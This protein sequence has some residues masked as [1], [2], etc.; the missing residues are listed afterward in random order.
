MTKLPRLLIAAIG[1]LLSLIACA[2]AQPVPAWLDNDPGAIWRRAPGLY[3]DGGHWYAILHTRPDIRR[4]RLVADFTDGSA[5]AFDLTPTP[6]GKFWWLKGRQTDFTRPPSAGDC[7]RFELTRHDG[8]TER[9]QDPAAR[10]VESSNL[11]ACSRVTIGSSYLWHDSSW[12][13]PGWEYYLTYELH[14]LRFSDRN[15]PLTPLQRITEELNGNGRDDYINDLH[16]TAIQLMPLN[17]FPGDLSWG[18]NPSFFYAIESSY[19]TPDQL[20]ELVDTAHQHGIAVVLDVELNHGGVGDNI[21][22]QVA[23]DDIRHGT[24]Y[25]GDTVWGPMV[26]FANDVARHFFVQNIVFLAREY[27]IDAFRFDMTRPMHNQDDGNIRVRGSGG[28][29]EFLCE[30]RRQVKAVDSGILLIAEELPNDWGLTVENASFG[31]AP[32]GHGPFDSQWSDPFHD[33]LA[34][35]LAGGN[36]AQLSDAFTSHGDNWQDEVI[37]TE[38][39]DEVG[40]V[41]GRI[42]RRGRD[43]KGW[44]MDQIAGAAT[45]LARGIP[46]L[47][48]GQEAGEDLQFGQDDGRVDARTAPTW[49]D[50]RLPLTAYEGDSGRSKVRLWW[51]RMLDIRRGDLGRF[52]WGDITLT[53]LNDANGVVAFTRDAGKYLVV[54]NLKGSS[55]DRYDVGVRGLY[56][57][58]A[59]TSW[60]AFNLGSY[61]ERT[62]GG[63]RAFDITDVP[64]PA[65]GVVVLVR[66]D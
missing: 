5:A 22:W 23:Q 8:A 39:H 58:L 64:I 60:P 14:P 27:H 40:N 55:W 65:Y 17:E 31:C 3:E 11:A 48:M 56:Q 26:H 25:D 34:D 32:D 4:V 1:Q 10:Q 63:E 28:G 57:E 37:Y 19:G 41:D 20:K 47:F 6:D 49:W 59:N 42:A 12:R 53:H 15:P 7:Y 54:V 36:L 35:V 66:W 13:R 30:I 52:A 2:H 9:I 38:S 44:E 45:V 46:M 18:Y 21:L 33:R 61:P 51:R 16:V 43:G 24:Y 62:R 50:D 29:W